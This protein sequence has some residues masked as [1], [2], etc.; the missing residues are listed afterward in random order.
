M[1]GCMIWSH[2]VTLEPSAK[3]R[4]QKS[5]MQSREKG[6]FISN[7]PNLSFAG[8]ANDWGLPIKNS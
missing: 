8:D 3:V 1:W 6:Y 2:I 4:H 5:I 7:S